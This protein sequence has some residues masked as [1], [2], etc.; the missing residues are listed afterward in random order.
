MK[1]EE[2]W[3][4]LIENVPDIIMVV[5][6][7]GIIQFVNHTVPGMTTEQVVGKK[8]YDFISAEHH[9]I[10]RKYVEQVFQ[11]GVGENYEIRGIGPHDTTS[12]YWSCIG[13]IKDQGH[14][15]AASIITR[16]ITERKKVEEELKESEQRFRTIFDN[17]A[18]GIV[19]ADVE[20]R[21][22]HT[23]NKKFCEMLGYKEE[24]V[25]NLGVTDIHPK[26]NLAYII[27]DFERQVRKELTVSKDIPV[28]RKDGSIFYSDINAIPISLEGK[29]YLLGIFRDITE[30]KKAEEEIKRLGSA[31]EQS[32]DGIGIG[33]LETRLLYVNRAYAEMHGYS[34]EEMIGM[35]VDGLHNEEYIDKFNRALCHFIER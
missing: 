27:D 33:D 24:E 3:H 4:S 23:C 11:T 8:L 1:S 16:D 35:K 22:L 18:D 25:K 30:R 26:E 2:K 28:K 34:P 5:D 19:L 13:P 10:M 12:W 20:G 21:K 32:I 9:E 31:V 17:A 29:R 6:R 7:D 15:V 14:I